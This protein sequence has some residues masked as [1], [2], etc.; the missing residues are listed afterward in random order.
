MD[1]DSVCFM[2]DYL[3]RQ[4][5]IILKKPPRSRRHVILFATR[6]SADVILLGPKRPKRL[7]E[8]AMKETQFVYL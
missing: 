5:H 2:T 7:L 1:A 6:R 4:T 3:P 8:Y